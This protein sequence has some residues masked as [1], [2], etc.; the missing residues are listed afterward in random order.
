MLHLINIFNH[1]SH[2]FSIRKSKIFNFAFPLFN[3]CLTNFVEQ[4]ISNCCWMWTFFVACFYLNQLINFQFSTMEFLK[5]KKL[6]KGIFDFKIRIYHVEILFKLICHPYFQMSL[7][8]CL[9]YLYFFKHSNCLQV[10]YV[11]LKI[12]FLFLFL[13][14]DSVFIFF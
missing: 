12:D 3:Y 5:I 13:L 14:P 1:L 8:F 7:L 6:I 4:L 10:L 2:S 11:L 9:A